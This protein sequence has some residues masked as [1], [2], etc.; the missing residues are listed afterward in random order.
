MAFLR[1]LSRGLQR[2]ALLGLTACADTA[3][4]DTAEA[5]ALV[6]A[7]ATVQR[8]YDVLETGGAGQLRQI[9]S[10]LDGAAKASEDGQAYFYAGAFR[11]WAIVNSSTVGDLLALPTLIQ[12]GLKSLER[13]HQLLPNDFRATSFLG[14]GQLTIGNMLGDQALIAAGLRTFETGFAQMP[15][16][17]YYLRA[18]SQSGAGRESASFKMAL[19]DMRALMR[20]CAYPPGEQPYSFRYPSAP[21]EA[22]VPWVC[23]NEGMVPHVWEGVFTTYGDIM[24]K[25]GDVAAGRALYRSVQTAPHYADWPYR[26]LLEERLQT[27]DARAAQYADRNP[28]NDP[29]MWTAGPHTCVGCHQEGGTPVR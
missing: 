17:A 5:R 27:A 6:V 16:Y 12:D 11:I 26:S 21:K 8:A 15:Q 10:E 4:D 1:L 28:L 24:L 19:E 3:H 13:G 9:L 25:A 7:D 23:L 14:L 2:I 22:P 20:G 18:V 29:V